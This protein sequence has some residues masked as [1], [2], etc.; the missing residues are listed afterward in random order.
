MKNSIKFDFVLN[1]KWIG[2]L[3]KVKIIEKRSQGELLRKRIF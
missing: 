2:D 1:D 3:D